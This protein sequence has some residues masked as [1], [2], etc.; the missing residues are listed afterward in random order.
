MA[1][2]KDDIVDYIKN[3]HPN[4]Y[5]LVCGDNELSSEQV[6][7]RLGNTNIEEEEGQKFLEEMLDLLGAER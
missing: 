4:I 1:N 5:E 2:Q 3:F 7:H 6:L